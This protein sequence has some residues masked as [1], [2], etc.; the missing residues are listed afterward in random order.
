MGMTDDSPFI[1]EL[2]CQQRRREKQLCMASEWHW[3]PDASPLS[4][5]LHC[6]EREECAVNKEKWMGG[7][8]FKETVKKNVI[9]YS[10]VCHSK[11]L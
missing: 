6:E 8:T 4:R 2:R 11:L 1:H 7:V 10:L 5:S 9:I 3:H